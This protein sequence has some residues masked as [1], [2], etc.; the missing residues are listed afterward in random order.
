M[1]DYVY[2]TYMKENYQLEFL[3]TVLKDNGIIYMKKSNNP[4]GQ[5]LTGT[6]GIFSSDIYVP[7]DKLE[8]AKDLLTLIEN[9]EESEAEE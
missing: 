1:N 3:L 4:V 6:T 5:F 8:E 2:L 7:A 9:N